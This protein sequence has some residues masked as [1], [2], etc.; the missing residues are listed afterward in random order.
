MSVAD[1]CKAAGVNHATVYRWK[2]G[3]HVPRVASA[4]MLFAVLTKRTGRDYDDTLVR[5]R[6]CVRLSLVHKY[7][8]NRCYGEHIPESISRRYRDRGITVCEQWRANPGLFIEWA[9]NAGYQDGLQL[10]RINNDGNYE[11]GNCR[12]VTPQENTANRGSR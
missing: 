2:N 8:M 6:Q 9:V 3:A 10:D 11:P 4:S 7:M 1:L 12:F 5:L